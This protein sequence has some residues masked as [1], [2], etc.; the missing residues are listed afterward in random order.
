L[1]NFG[2]K[3]KI[4]LQKSPQLKRSG[5]AKLLTNQFGQLLWA[6]KKSDLVKVP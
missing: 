5:H 4:I 6:S 3:L 2:Q 1:E